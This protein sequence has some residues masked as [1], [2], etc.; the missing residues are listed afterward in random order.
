MASKNE[1]QPRFHVKLP[2]KYNLLFEM[3]LYV[4]IIML[5]LGPIS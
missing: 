4:I 5:D 3:T 2:N 1:L